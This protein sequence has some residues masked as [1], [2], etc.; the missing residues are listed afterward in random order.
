MKIK[1]KDNLLFLPYRESREFLIR[2][3]WGRETRPRDA[4]D[5]A[6]SVIGQT[7]AT[8]ASNRNAYDRLRILYEEL[9]YG[10]DSPQTLFERMQDRLGHDDIKKLRQAGISP[11]ELLNGFPTWETLEAKNI[12]DENY[13][14]KNI[15]FNFMD[16]MDVQE[17]DFY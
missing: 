16:L 15:P 5:V 3:I 1:R 11:E 9:V 14:N 17:Q 6:L 8:Y 7:Y 10:M 4:I 12:I 2:A 13:Q